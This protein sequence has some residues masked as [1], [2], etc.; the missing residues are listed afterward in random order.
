MIDFN[1]TVI[2]FDADR[3]PYYTSRG[4]KGKFEKVYLND[5]EQQAHKEH[6]AAKH[7]AATAPERGRTASFQA[8]DTLPSGPTGVLG[9]GLGDVGRVSIMPVGLESG[10]DESAPAR[11]TVR[12]VVNL[13]NSMAQLSSSLYWFGAIDTDVISELA[14]RVE[15][16]S[17]VCENDAECVDDGGLVSAHT[18]VDRIA[19]HMYDAYN[20]NRSGTPMFV[21]AQHVAPVVTL[22]QYLM[23]IVFPDS[24]MAVRAQQ[25]SLMF[26][27]TDALNNLVSDLCTVYNNIQ[28]DL[29]H[30]GETL[31]GYVPQE[32]GGELEVY[33]NMSQI[34]LVNAADEM[35][36][37]LSLRMDSLTELLNEQM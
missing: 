24:D 29:G 18:F 11:R 37:Y 22:A 34:G 32:I 8:V 7:V 21:V 17:P 30:A 2:R 16:Y 20:D 5:A 19:Y 26:R 33:E 14:Q 13:I 31:V 15:N 12:R 3:R 35:V 9:P 23:G 27:R 10:A 6:E 36:N 28:A 1:T 25:Q 4:A